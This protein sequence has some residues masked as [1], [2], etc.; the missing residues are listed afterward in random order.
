M[1]TPA[2][3]AANFSAEKKVSVSS[4]NQTQSTKTSAS[5][6]APAPASAPAQ[7]PAPQA[8]TQAQ[9]TTPAQPIAPQITNSPSSSQ[10]ISSQVPVSVVTTPSSISSSSTTPA[11]LSSKPPTTPLGS[12]NA[13]VRSTLVKQN[14]KKITHVAYAI[15]H[16]S[17]K[18]MESWRSTIGY[19][20]ESELIIYWRV[21]EEAMKRVSE[22]NTEILSIIQGFAYAAEVFATAMQ[23]NGDRSRAVAIGRIQAAASA[24]HAAVDAASVSSPAVHGKNALSLSI[25]LNALGEVHSQISSALHEASGIASRQIV[26][27]MS[28]PSSNSNSNGL[29]GS[30]KS[31]KEGVLPPKRIPTRAELDFTAPPPRDLSGL[32]SWCDALMNE[33]IKE[34]DV[35]ASTLAEANVMAEKAFDDFETLTHAFMTGDVKKTKGGDLWLSELRYRRVMRGLLSVKA[36]YLAVMAL[37]FE[38]FRKMEAHRSEI[39]STALDSF[40][41]LTAKVFDRVSVKA[42][43][44]SLKNI[45]TH[46]DFCKMVEEESRSRIS[47][48]RTLSA[49]TA[50][51]SGSVLSSS[52]SSTASSSGGGG[53]GGGR[54]IQGGGSS[55]GGRGGDS[56]IKFTIELLPAVMSPFASPLVLRTGVLYYRHGVI[57]HWNRF[58]G[59]LTRDF[60]LHLFNITDDFASHSDVLYAIFPHLTEKEGGVSSSCGHS[61]LTPPSN[62]SSSSSIV[63]IGGGREVATSPLPDASPSSEDITDAAMSSSSSQSTLP[64]KV[65]SSGGIPKPALPHELILLSA[66]YSARIDPSSTAISSAERIEGKGATGGTDDPVLSMMRKAGNAPLVSFELSGSSKLLFAPSIHQHAFTISD[67][68]KKGWFSS[69]S[70]VALRA[71]NASDSLEWQVALSKCIEILASS[72]TI[73]ASS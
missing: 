9:T 46:A 63:N 25:S 33:I 72:A 35:L 56:H 47:R 18:E 20:Q 64:Q 14:E 3:T 42:L 53:G 34:G 49:A 36:R 19:E 6:S 2:N 32:A 51:S 29:V 45:N 73:D 31:I 39:F 68:T 17:V 21:W 15:T 61:S 58:I 4:N 5:A 23:R 16:K 22:S 52:S 38:K 43:Q 26:G 24:S 41:G 7:S 30:S 54:P 70:S 1:S 10:S 57:K 28:N 40:S 48:S 66:N 59:V 60:H 50:T 65:P 11:P 13:V 67:D 69:G 12:T 71:L 37:L 62:L 55:G 27:F 8:Q 44:D